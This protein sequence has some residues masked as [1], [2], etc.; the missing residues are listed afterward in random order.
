MQSAPAGQRAKSMSL[1]QKYLRK[2]PQYTRSAR[3]LRSVLQ[4]GTPK[5]W[6]NL[7]KVEYERKL[8]RVS[9]KSHPYLIFLDPCNY[10]DLQCPLCPT[11]TNEL[12]RPQTMLS[13]EHFKKYFEPHSSYLFEVIMHNWGE[14]MLN[15]DV[16]KM[17]AHAQGS[18]VGTNLSSNLVNTASDDIDR[19]LD[20]GLEYLIVSLDGTSQ[21]VYEKY[22]VR[23]DIGR[24][25]ANLKA[26]LSRRAQRNMSTPVVEWQYIVMKQNEHEIGEA[27]R[28]STELGV[29]VMRFIPVGLP[30]E[31]ENRSQLA[32][33]WFP[34][35]LEGR[36]G[37][38][39]GEQTYGQDGR[40][41]PCYYLY[42]SMTINPDGGVSPCCIVYKQ[43]RDF[44]SLNTPNIEIEAIW[45]NPKFRSGRSLFSSE[46][47]PARV[48]TI[49]DDCTIFEWHPDKRAAVDPAPVGP[50]GVSSLKG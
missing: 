50:E 30:F 10:C 3:H 33:E 34:T 48:R 4:H 18:N 23:G 44:A 1:A 20:S 2:I 5:K 47:I 35:D 25:H 26:L 9:V 12:G 39:P 13:F 31:A 36:V 22:R 16:F 7:L 11:G 41:G 15:K 17:I 49:C 24:V 42:R 21:E 19:L 14:S 6:A 27:E 29:D 46:E 45:N 40:P 38:T 8:R 28:M 43:E 37:S 32:A